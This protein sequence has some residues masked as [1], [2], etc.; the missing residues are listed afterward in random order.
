MADIWNKTSRYFK[1]K[2]YLIYIAPTIIIL[3]ILVTVPTLFLWLISFTNYEMGYD[4]FSAKFVGL[5]NY[6]RLFGGGDSV[7]Y[8]SLWISMLFMLIT[9]S[10]EL[11]LGYLIAALLNLKEFALKSVVVGCLIV[12]IAMTPSIA[13]QIWKLILNS[14]YGVLNYLLNMFF[15]FKITWLGPENSFMSI[16]MIDIWQWTPYVAVILYAG[17]RSMPAEPQE[18]AMVEGAN[19]L[20]RFYYITLPILKPLIVLVLLFRSIDSLK[21]FDIPYVL[22]QGGPGNATELMSL[23]IFRLG[24]AQ[25]GFI[26]RAAAMS[27]VLTLIITL[28]SQLFMKMLFK[29]ETD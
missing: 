8:H 15:N 18:S 5:K 29:K 6:T 17:L 27:V 4:F 26:G 20:H 10:C 16:I 3:G 25:T 11:V 12:P 22:T 2:P 9:T 28:V 19:I 23:H 1:S 13:G 14:E 21:L 7:F 24:F